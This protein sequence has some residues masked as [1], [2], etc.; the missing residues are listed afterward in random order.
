MSTDFWAF[1]ILQHV[2]SRYGFLKT[3][4]LR[5]SI[6]RWYKLPV[7]CQAESPELCKYRQVANAENGATVADLEDVGDLGVVALFRFLQIFPG[8]RFSAAVHSLHTLAGSWIVCT[9]HHIY[10]GLT[11]IQRV[12]RT[13]FFCFCES[14]SWRRGQKG[15]VNV[16]P[17]A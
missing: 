15:N 14:A 17:G 13:E 4:K 1:N 7:L 12:I 3:T 10:I 8:S 9:R 16:S 5:R 11:Y 6:F 2:A